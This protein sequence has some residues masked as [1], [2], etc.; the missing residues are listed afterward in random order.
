[1]DCS[2]LQD[3]VA[4]APLQKEIIEDYR[5]KVPDDIIGLWNQYG[6]GNFKNGF[7]KIINPQIFVDILD[8][9]Y[10]RSNVSIPLFATG[11]GDIITWE[12]N[13]TFMLVNFGRK[14]LRGLANDVDVLFL[15]ITSDNFCISRMFGKN[16]FEAVE[17]Y[18]GLAYDECFGYV[19]L[20]G[21]GGPEKIENLQKVKIREQIL[22][23]THLL[24][25]FQ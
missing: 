24:G 1:M 15:S 17:K 14:V 6:L 23:I 9:A 4:F 25:P 8:T 20:L 7:I 11:M 21:L 16:Y 12:D 3:F 10:S 18:G 2:V 5:T 19:P 22:V 13:H